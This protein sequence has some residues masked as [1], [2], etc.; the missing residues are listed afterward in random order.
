MMLW[1]GVELILMQLTQIER[2]YIML[3]HHSVTLYHACT[4][5]VKK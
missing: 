2:F 1:L 3:P 4:M 5:W